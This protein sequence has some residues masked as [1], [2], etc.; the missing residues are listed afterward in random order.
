MEFK[1]K[2][3]LMTAKE[4]GKTLNTLAQEIAKKENLEKVALIGIRCRGVPLAERLAKELEKLGAKNLSLG[5]LDITLYR[6]DL[7]LVASQPIVKETKLPFGI[8]E[9][10]II[11]IDD[12]L[13]TG[14]TIRSALDALIDFGRPQGIKLA[15][16]IDRGNRELPIQADYIGKKISTSLK[17]MVKVELKEVDSKDEV[18]L[19]EK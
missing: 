10:V 8:D 11:L 12:V 15:V 16:L 3:V 4:I 18:S 5:I 14:R 19:W 1:K 2:K 13:F 6:D 17:E 7:S 9:K